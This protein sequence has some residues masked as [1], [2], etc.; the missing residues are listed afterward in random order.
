MERFQGVGTYYLNHYL[1]WSPW[2]ELH[3]NLAFENRVEQM[4]IS[5]CQKSNHY[6]VEAL[7]KDKKYDL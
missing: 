7:R 2:L 3:K 4:I 6:T 1:Y 5:A